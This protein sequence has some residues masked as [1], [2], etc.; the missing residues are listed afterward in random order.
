M[1]IP[2]AA[3]DA[4][5]LHALFADEYA[6]R[7]R[8]SP[9]F[10]MSK[11]HY[12]HA[13]RIGDPSL[14]AIE[15]RH[16][17][18]QEFLARL[19]K[20]D[21]AALTPDDQ[22]NYDLFE[23]ELQQ[24]V[25]GHRFRQFLA[26][27]GGRFGP[28]QD[29]PQMHERVRFASR[30]D[31]ENYLKR[32]EATPAA[33][34]AVIELLQTGLAEGRT[35]PRVAMTGVPDQFA[36]LLTAGG[37]DML[38]A[39][40]EQMPA[41]ITDD[42]GRALKRRFEQQS[43]PAVRAGLSELGEFVTQTYIPGCRESIAARDW[44]DGEAMYAYQLRLMT[45]ISMSADE[46]HQLGLR[47]V[48]RIR[49]EMLAVIR[50]SDFMQRQ[51]QA[52]TWSDDELFRRFLEYLRTDPR[53]YYQQ[54][55]ELM[56]GY[57]DICKR[58]DAELPRLFGTLPRL[59]FGV[60]EIPAFM[61]PAQ[62]TA[63]YHPGNLKNAEAGVFYAN[64]YKLDQRPRYEMVPLALHEAV[65]GHH[66]Q[67]ALAQELEGLPEF[68]KD[69]WFQ[70][71]GEGWALY[72]ERLGIEMGLFVDPYDDFGRL[73]YEMWRACRLVVDPG[74]HA[75]GWSR[76]QAVRYM[77]ENTALSELN[78]NAEVDRYIAWPGQATAYK[79]GELRIRALREQAEQRLG[80]RF[81]V[82]AFHDEL[83]SAGTLPLE[84]LD[85]RMAAWMERQAAAERPTK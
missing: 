29:I 72:A 1:T 14:A 6:W 83:L 51:E 5:K 21:R 76:A 3:Q 66:F 38:A 8:E 48:A 62:T 16:A 73:L 54:P 32:L 58:V 64:T 45:T 46:I 59:T 70:A 31:Y 42:E 49:A 85:R 36:K 68:R 23:R 75:L 26:P 11:G 4:A 39:P 37:L 19:R 41:G 61:A 34:R 40:L 60:K 10:A 22:L 79:I 50:R 56:R 55:E 74:M 63:Y 44:P 53:F 47:E 33:A 18:R 28:Q 43:L 35:P 13:D 78:I 81:D 12:E 15:R 84:V 17:E 30:L 65:P 71:F 20:L 57:R 24:E 69:A 52:Q 2:A 80:G 67:I 25:D 9:E 7:L 82:R 77:L 27:V